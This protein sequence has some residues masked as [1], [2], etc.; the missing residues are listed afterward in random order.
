MSN[1]RCP[2]CADEELVLADRHHT[3]GSC[4]GVFVAGDDLVAMIGELTSEPYELGPLP[5]LP[6]ARD[7]PLCSNRMAV[8]VLFEVNVDRCGTHG[9]WFDAKELESSLERAAG[10]TGPL[11][12]AKQFWDKFWFELA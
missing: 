12:R 5:E 4:E 9:V 3:C 11:S 8:F 7:C 1:P 6:G 10:I 2:S